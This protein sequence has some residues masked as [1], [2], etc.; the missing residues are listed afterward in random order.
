MSTKIYEAYEF[1]GKG[2]ISQLTESLKLLKKEYMKNVEKVIL[3]IVK[4]DREGNKDYFDDDGKFS[5]KK[6][7][8]KS[9]R[10]PVGSG[11]RAR[12]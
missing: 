2:G 1:K 10:E 7:G 8:D 6:L 5:F 11:G 4:R 3:D 12:A 9:R